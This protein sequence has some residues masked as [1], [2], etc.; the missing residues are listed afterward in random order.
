MEMTSSSAQHSV[1]ETAHDAGGTGRDKQRTGT[2]YAL[3]LYRREFDWYKAA[4]TDD[5]DTEVQTQPHNSSP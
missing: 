2:V 4:R 3:P 5:E 1:G